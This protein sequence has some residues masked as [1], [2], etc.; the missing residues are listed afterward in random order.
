MKKYNEVEVI[1]YLSYLIK[2]FEQKELV[3]WIGSTIQPVIARQEERVKKFFVGLK[4]T[5][6]IYL[7]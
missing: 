6:A 7:S 3:R 4:N 2:D 1:L 5:P